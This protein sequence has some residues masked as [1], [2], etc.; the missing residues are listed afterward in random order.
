[1]MGIP[2]LLIEHAYMDNPEDLV[3]LRD[4]EKVD[5]IGRRDA[6]AIVEYYG[7][8]MEKENGDIT[9]ALGGDALLDIEI[10]NVSAPYFI[11]KVYVRMW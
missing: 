6:Q 3:F 4:S 9:A 2:S 8:S 11:E 7:L 10:T 5:E 1:M